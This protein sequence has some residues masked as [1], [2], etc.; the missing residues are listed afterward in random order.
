MQAKIREKTFENLLPLAMSSS[1][2]RKRTWTAGN[3]ERGFLFPFVTSLKFNVLFVKKLNK[4][5]N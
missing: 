5:V 4:K 1:R 3:S 2:R